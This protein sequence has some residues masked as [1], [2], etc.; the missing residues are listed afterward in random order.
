MMAFWN[1]FHCLYCD[2]EVRKIAA[3]WAWEQ[4]L[5][6]N[7][8]AKGEGVRRRV[9]CGSLGD[10]FEDWQGP[11]H[12][13]GGG[14]W[15]IGNSVQRIGSMDDV[16]VRLFTLIDQTPN[17]D[18]LLLTKRPENIMRM[19]PPVET[20]INYRRRKGS[21]NCTPNPFPHSTR[22][23]EHD[24][25]RPNLF[26]GTSVENQ[27]AADERIPHLLKVP[28][29]VRFLSCEPLLGDIRFA[30]NVHNLY[31]GIH[32]AIIG[33]ESGPDARVCQVWVRNLLQQFDCAGVEVF[34]KQ[35][36]ANVTTRLPSGEH[37]PRHDGPSSPVQ[38]QGDGF[39]NYYVSGL[40]HTKGGDPAEWPID[41]R[42][43]QFPEVVQDG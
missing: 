2:S 3:D 36:G 1:T 39:G 37:W 25:I 32:W 20:T 5:V 13:V 19:M 34:V 15:W 26:L 38:F 17:L 40:L 6:W 31:G 30:S 24:R 35:L 33:G 10:V 7:R 27:A 22:V 18:W 28:A 11:M 4:V 14:N 43:R 12:V 21:S 29:K 8:R 16:R 41:L 42:V 23:I 9:L